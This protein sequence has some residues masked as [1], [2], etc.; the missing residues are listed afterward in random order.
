MAEPERRSFGSLPAAMAVFM[1]AMLLTAGFTLFAWQSTQAQERLT[2]EALARRTQITITQRMQ[3]YINLLYAGRAFL[4]GSDEV[5]RQDWKAFVTALDIGQRFPG[6][7]GIGYTVRIPPGGLLAHVAEVR[8]S[9]LPNYRVWPAG[10]RPEFTAILYLEPLD[11]RNQA[12]LGYDMFSE[13]IRQEAMTRARDTGKPAMSGKVRLVQ[14]I[15]ED[16]QAGCLIYLPFYRDDVP[17]TTVEERRQALIGY[18][19]AP[20]RADD[21]FTGLFGTSRHPLI[22]FE[23]YDGSPAADNLLHDHN[24]AFRPQNTR[25]RTHQMSIPAVVAGRTWTIVYTA[26]P[27]FTKEEDD[28]LVLIVFLAGTLVS[29]LLA[30]ITWSLASSRSRALAMANDMTAELRQADQAKDEF[31]SVISHELRTPLNF[32]MGFG[33]IL[34][35]EVPG[36]L[37]PKQHEF[38]G[39]MLSGVDRMLVLVNDLLDFAKIQAGKLDLHPSRTDVVPLMTEVH[40]SLKPLADQKGITFA[41]DV[42]ERLDA[43]LDGPRIVQV[44]NNLVGNAIKFTLPGGAIVIKGR[45]D[46]DELL[47]E[48]IDTGIG[49]SAEDLPKLFTRFRQLDMSSTRKA[50]GTGLGLSISKA[51][52]EEHG[53]RIGVQSV[54]GEGSTFW[55]RLPLDGPNLES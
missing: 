41:V 33:S 8:R 17:T 40:S 50:G 19:Y 7:Q 3:T 18:V 43:T 1:L 32:I 27:Q 6:I 9:G 5:T 4:E 52:V 30:G 25:S 14:E 13:P 20:F 53:G 47:V 39:K 46:R 49:I 44:L 2:F 45:R 21:L 10:D 48:V 12:A 51:L 54:Q 11:A 24:P 35:D 22:D 55:F 37:N 42:P 16:K 23:I 34:E 31:L 15:T 36:P 29:L 26:T 28:G 38:L